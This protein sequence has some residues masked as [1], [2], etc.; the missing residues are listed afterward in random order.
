MSTPSFARI[1]ASA[2]TQRERSSTCPAVDELPKVRL[3]E[4]VKFPGKG[5]AKQAVSRNLG[6]PMSTR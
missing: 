5:A 2:A 6:H 1:G 3:D 4:I